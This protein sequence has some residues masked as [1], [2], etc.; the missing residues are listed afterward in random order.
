MKTAFLHGELREEAFVSQPEGFM[1]ER[2]E[3]M[4]YKLNKALYGLRQAPRAWNHKLNQI[5]MELNFVR[6]AKEPAFYRK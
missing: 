2:S 5:L 1:K 3:G 6:C 4:V